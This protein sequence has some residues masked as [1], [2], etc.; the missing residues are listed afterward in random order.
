MVEAKGRSR[1]KLDR[2]K[3]KE[4]TQ[5]INQCALR[6]QKN[7]GDIEA[8]EAIHKALH[9]FIS[10]QAFH[11]FII[12]GHEGKDLYQEALIVL[13]QK[14]IPS[15]DATRG[16]SFLGFARMCINRHLITILNSAINRKKDMPMNR[17][18]SLDEVYS[19]DGEG[20]GCS[21]SNL[22]PDEGDF[23]E[24]ICSDEDQ[25][26]TISKLVVSLSVFE[27]AVLMRYL[28]GMS[29]RDIAES[30]TEDMDRDCNEKSVDNALL[31]IRRKAVEL[32]GSDEFIPL[33]EQ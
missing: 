29:Y 26:T 33:F 32:L 1:Q 11:R 12:R 10:G 28:E 30:V 19:T 17:S 7:P 27:A 2:T 4:F 24:D 23:V 14:A 18:V 22:L 9:K 20:D 3:Q 31:R 16:M 25:E 5:H 8:F 6:L 21:L 13:W 15:F